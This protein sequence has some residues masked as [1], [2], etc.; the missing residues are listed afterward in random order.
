MTTL[1]ALRVCP[2]GVYKAQ[3]KR[4][5]NVSSPSSPQPWRAGGV[6]GSSSYLQ[7][8]PAALRGVAN[9]CSLEDVVPCDWHLT[10]GMVLTSASAPGQHSPIWTIPTPP[11][12]TGIPQEPG[13]I[14]QLL[15]A[16]V[17]R[18]SEGWG[19]AGQQR[20]QE[21]RDLPQSLSKVTVGPRPGTGL[22]ALGQML[23]KE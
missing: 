12:P 2:N 16:V 3:G 21:A 20:P 14:L 8:K 5:V 1:G 9:T 15:L 10:L 18:C 17:R 13:Y 4:S 19:V 23:L 22:L 11:L 7:K 6:E